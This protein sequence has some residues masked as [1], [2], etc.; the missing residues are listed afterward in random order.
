MT[1]ASFH[2]PS[3]CPACI[4]LPEDQLARAQAAVPQAKGALR[5]IVLALPEIHCAACIDGV[6]RIMAATPGVEA[7][8]VNLSLRRVTVTLADDGLEPEDVADA[9]S[10]RGFRA[11]PLDSATLAAAGTDREGKALLARLG[12]AGFATMNVMLLSVAVWSGASDATRDLLHWISAA[13]ALPVVAFAGMP[14]YTS[15]WSA[16]RGGRL[17]MDVPITL[18]IALAAILSLLETMESGHHAYFDAAVSLTFFLLIGRYLDHRTRAAARSA[19]TELAALDVLTAMRVAPDGTPEKV[20]ADALKPGDLLFVPPGAKIPADGPIVEGRSDVDRAM[21]TG[22]SL[23]ATVG[24]GD[25]VRAGMVNLTGPLTIRAEKLGDDTLLREIARLVDAAEGA[26]NRYTRLADKA[27]AL[28]APGVHILALIA[29]IGWMVWSG[30]LRVSLNVAAAVLIITCPCALGLAVPSVQAAASGLLYR[31]GVLVK[32][33]TALEKLAE[34]DTV[35]FDKTGTLTTELPLYASGPDAASDAFA[36]A[37]ALARNSTHPLSE[38]IATEARHRG[39]RAVPVAVEVLEVVDG[40][41]DAGVIVV[42][43]QVAVVVHSVADL[44]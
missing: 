2:G 1:D 19:A 16:L 36:I 39:A 4:G 27:V 7:A 29:F 9:L 30:D 12:V 37:H 34:V 42:D 22:E 17:N 6:E 43:Q 41:R 8:R 5:R 20:A 14:F 44:G 3:A 25:A 23:P 40:A 11:L 32:D 10:A 15:A 24:E 21:L 26:K 28:Y 13:I 35:V 31:M 33:G 38:A 18:A